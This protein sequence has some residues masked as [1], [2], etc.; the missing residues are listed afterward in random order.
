MTVEFGVQSV[1]HV[2][3]EFGKGDRITGPVAPQ[4]E[5]NHAVPRVSNKAKSKVGLEFGIG[6]D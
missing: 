1:S 4:P 6:D 5:R 3:Q 2:S